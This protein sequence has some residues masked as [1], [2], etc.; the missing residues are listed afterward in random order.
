MRICSTI[1]GLASVVTSPIS[2]VL[3]MEASTRRMGCRCGKRC[4]ASFI[5]RPRSRSALRGVPEIVA[6]SRQTGNG[7]NQE[8]PRA[9]RALR[10]AR[11]REGMRSTGCATAAA[12]RRRR[13]ASPG[14]P[15]LP[16]MPGSQRELSEMGR[17]SAPMTNR[18]GGFSFAVR[19]VRARSQL[20]LGEIAFTG[21]KRPGATPGQWAEGRAGARV[22]VWPQVHLKH[23]R[24]KILFAR[25][26]KGWFPEEPIHDRARRERID[27][28]P[29]PLREELHK[30][31]VNEAAARP[32]KVGIVGQ[33]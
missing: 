28:A 14:G 20:Y 30:S 1:S 18:T 19:T 27:T 12:G 6:A 21:P 3:E 32:C 15:S 8:T 7:R 25:R 9:S 33:A 4:G 5:A 26:T 17:S 11:S 10:T 24:E 31:R 2:I 22:L 16:C 29:H 13:R 23:G